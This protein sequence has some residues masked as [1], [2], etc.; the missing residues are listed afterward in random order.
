MKIPKEGEY[1]KGN[2]TDY[3]FLKV[4]SKFYK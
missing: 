2:S 4:E 3:I 1:L